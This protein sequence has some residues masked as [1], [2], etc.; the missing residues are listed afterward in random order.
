[1]PNMEN[2]TLPPPAPMREYTRREVAAA[3]LP[4]AAMLLLGAATIAL[5]F[6]HTP[7][8]VA[9]ALV[10]AL[11]GVGGAVWIMIFVCPYCAYYGT[12]GC[13]CG[14]GVVAARLVRKSELEC[15][16]Q[17][18]KRHIPVIVPLWI[19]PVAAG[20]VAL[21]QSFNGWLLGLVGVFAVNSYV[22]LPLLAQR[23]S[24]GDCPQREGCPWMSAKQS[25]RGG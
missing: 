2:V 11:Y 18:F 24:C 8:V 23:H 15:F 25:P 22:V 20:V 19:I 16:A 14:Y 1:M 10:Y 12:R 13:P 7:W 5:G 9:A 6:H 21:V 3:N 4:Y 17:K